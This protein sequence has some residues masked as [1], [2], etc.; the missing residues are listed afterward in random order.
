MI[1]PTKNQ[2]VRNN[3]PNWMNPKL[4]IQAGKKALGMK[5]EAS[6]ESNPIV[7]SYLCMNCNKTFQASNPEFI[8][9]ATL[10]RKAKTVVELSCPICSNKVTANKTIEGIKPVSNL[11]SIQ[12]EKRLDLT[13]EASMGDHNS[14]VEQHFTYKAIQALSDYAADQGMFAPTVR[15]LRG[16]RS[17]RPEMK[18]ATLNDIECSIEWLFGRRQKMYCTAS[19]KMD[20]QGKYEFPKT[21]KVASG[22]EYPFEEKYIRS[23]EYESSFPQQTVTRKKTDIPV[24]RKPDITR[25]FAP[26][27]GTPGFSL[28]A[29]KNDVKKVGSY[30]EETNDSK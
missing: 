7:V 9:Q 12:T 21:F 11:Q 30:K 17:T 27:G 25:S 15:Y 24:Y 18:F 2:N 1:I 14:Q 4:V 16:E 28:T 13:K 20:S 26:S 5:K 22:K 3:I 6:I 10:A 8:K 29:S 23:I 19:V